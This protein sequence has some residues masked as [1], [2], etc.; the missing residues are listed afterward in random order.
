M[1]TLRR[2][3]R[4]PAHRHPF[5][6]HARFNLALV[7]TVLLVAWVAVPTVARFLNAW[8]GYAP[9]W[10]EPKDLERQTWLERTAAD[11]LL[12]RL[13]WSDL[14]GIALFVLVAVVWL[15]LM[16]DRVSRRRPQ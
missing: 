3:H 1:T 6:R 12:G 15:T 4:H 10:Y 8:A 9:L 2:A 5:G 13:E 7:L 14:I 16:P 11:A